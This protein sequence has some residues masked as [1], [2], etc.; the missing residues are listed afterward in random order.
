L[1]KLFCLSLLDDRKSLN[2][3]RARDFWTILQKGV[4]KIIYC[5]SSRVKGWLFPARQER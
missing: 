2:I 4:W 3:N 5:T 1:Y